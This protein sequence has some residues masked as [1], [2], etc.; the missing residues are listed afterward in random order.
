MNNSQQAAAQQ[1]TLPWYLLSIRG[2]LAPATLESARQL[3]NSTAGATENVAA[4]RALGDLSH[5]VYVPAGGPGAGPDEFLILDV[6]NNIEGL[7]QFFANPT[8]QEQAGQIFSTRDPV[9]WTPA[10]G[11]FTYHLPAPHGQNERIVAV[12]RGTV[13]SHDEARAVHNAIVGG[14]IN[15][16]RRAGDL[17]HEVYL[18]MAPP[19]SPEA[20]E[21]LAVDVW[22]S[23]SGM[24]EYYQNPEFGAGVQ[25]LF[26]APP[27]TSVWVHPAGDW[28]EW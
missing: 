11:F 20:L 17:S 1:Q 4:A 22:M 25:K 14:E 2:T 24:S 12:V 15:K 5:M 27:A 10:P 7:G 3:H 13:R 26:A 21:L 6:W 23:A 28:V 16:V 19:D 8:V 18:R 9:V